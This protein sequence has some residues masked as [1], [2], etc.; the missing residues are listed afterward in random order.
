MMFFLDNLLSLGINNN[1]PRANVD[2][3]GF[4][5]YAVACFEG[6]PI[7]AHTT[8]PSFHK[9][10]G[11]Q[12]KLCRPKSIITA[13]QCEQWISYK[14]WKHFP[15]PK[16]KKWETYPQWGM[17]VKVTYTL[18]GLLSHMINLIHNG[19]CTKINLLKTQTNYIPWIFNHSVWRTARYISLKT[20]NLLKGLHLQPREGIIQNLHNAR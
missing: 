13:T 17:S 7:G 20:D 10:L 1:R 18:L 6:C 9:G 8:T 11:W 15:V 4:L 5:P 16:K 2:P 19:A 12:Q 14:A 3:P